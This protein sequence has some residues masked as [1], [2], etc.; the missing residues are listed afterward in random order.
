[1]RHSSYQCNCHQRTSNEKNGGYKVVSA[2]WLCHI[3]NQF[4]QQQP[5]T[6]QFFFGTSHEAL[7]TLHHYLDHRTS[8]VVDVFKLGTTR[9]NSE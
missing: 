7:S 4:K 8:P 2:S 1:M 6:V 9:N 5:G 3:V